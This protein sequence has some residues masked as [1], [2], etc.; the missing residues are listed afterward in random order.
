MLQKVQRH[1]EESE[2]SWC[3]QA[4]GLRKTKH[5]DSEKRNAFILFYSRLHLHTAQLLHYYE[6]TYI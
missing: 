5:G 6:T 4:K 3:Q 1:R 2:K